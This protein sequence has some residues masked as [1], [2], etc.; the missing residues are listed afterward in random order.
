MA[1]NLIIKIGAEAKEFSDAIKGI[2]SQTEDLESGLTSVAKVS[3]AVFAGLVATAGVAI[4]AFADSEK[5]SKQLEIALQNQGIA[6]DDLI[7]KYKGLAESIQ[8]KTGVDDDAIVSGE[9]VLQNFLGQAEASEELLTAM[10]DLA[11]K[12]GSVESAAEILGRGIAGNTKGLKQFGIEIDATATKEERIALITE[13]VT[14]RFGGMAAKANEGTGSVR[15]L[16]TSFGNFLE[17][18]GERLAPTFNVIVASLTKFFDELSKNEPLLDFIVEVGKIAGIIAGVVTAMATAAL[19]IVQFQK[20][21][22]VAETA[23]K[24]LGISTRV[25]VGATGI[26]LL[27]IVIAEVALN[28]NKIWPALVAVYETFVAN[29]SRISGA[30]VK[31]LEGITFFSPSKLKEGI[32]EAEAIVKEGFKNIQNSV[33]KDGVELGV[34]QDEKKAVA[35][36]KSAQEQAQAERDKVAVIVAQEE[37]VVLESEKASQARVDL[38]KQEIETLKKLTEDQYDGEREALSTQLETIRL[39]EEEAITTEQEQKDTLNNEILA[40]NEEFNSLSLQQQAIFLEKNRVA[41]Q[42]ATLTKAQVEEKAVQESLKRQTD[43][44]NRFLVEQQKYGAAYAT[45]NKTIYS[46]QVQGAQQ[47]FGELARLQTS[48]NATLKAIGKAAAVAQIT[49][50]TAVSAMN[51]FTGFQSLPFGIGIAL[52]I[53]G[54]AA[55]VAFGAEQIGRVLSA[56]D[57]GLVPGFNQGGDSVPAVLQPGELVVPRANFG[58]VVNAVASQRINESPEAT[59]GIG[60]GPSG[61]QEVKVNLQFSGDNAEKFLTARQVEA[62]SLGT[63]REATA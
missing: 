23:I 15:G 31:I 46:D 25:A 3:G 2:K 19:T 20:A 38:K 8:A 52:G 48:N 32:K 60:T 55:A 13:Q 42:A 14:Q 57:G 47:S 56:E 22:L 10:V 7:K 44:N 54:A 59:S 33:P 53:A 18:V 61:P 11:E 39:L 43:A 41:L 1:D 29:L 24:I 28:W 37:L 12:T 51:I 30:V 21:L 35:A 63:L 9:A 40:K 50:Q 49:Y 58:E 6:S 36:K 4:K 16:Q 45:I 5:A 17:K 34:A 62:R 26:G 27:L